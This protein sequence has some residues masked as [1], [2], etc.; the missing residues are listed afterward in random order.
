MATS[1]KVH[2]RITTVTPDG[3][4]VVLEEG[5]L[6]STDEVSMSDTAIEH[7]VAQGDLEPIPD[8]KPKTA[9]RAATSKE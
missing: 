5:G 1:F 7:L 3:A 8:A 9:A 4:E 2:N 6:F